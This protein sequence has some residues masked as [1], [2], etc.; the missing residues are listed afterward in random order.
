M[1]LLL[2]LLILVTFVLG[3]RCTQSREDAKE[4]L[5]KYVDIDKNKQIDQNEID[6]ARSRNLYFYEKA[7]AWIVA[8]D[9]TEIMRKCDFNKN[10]VITLDDFEKSKGT[11]LSKCESIAKLFYYVCDREK[12][13]S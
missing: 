7:L 4:C 9:N 1:L 2:L 6:A 5:L 3:E 12:N 8:T 10:G 11:C 13:I